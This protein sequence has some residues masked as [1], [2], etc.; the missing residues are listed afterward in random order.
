MKKRRGAGNYKILKTHKSEKET[1]GVRGGKHAAKCERGGKKTLK[2]TYGVS[3]N[4]TW[5]D[6]DRAEVRKEDMGVIGWELMKIDSS[7]PVPR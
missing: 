2:E 6:R 7:Y 5:K 1:V 4:R 3:E